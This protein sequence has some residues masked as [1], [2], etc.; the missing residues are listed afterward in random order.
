MNETILRAKRVAALEVVENRNV[1]RLIAVTAFAIATALGAQVFVPLPFTP[2]P[3]TLQTAFVVLAGA[4]LGPRLG[5]ASQLAYLAMGVAGLPVFA[6]GGLGLAHLVGPTGGYLLAFPVTAYVAGLV[7][8]PSGR[9][10]VV[11]LVRLFAGLFIASLVILAG[12]AAW[13]AAVTGDVSGALT[14]AVVPFLIGD[15]VK[16]GLVALIAWRG[17]DRTLGLL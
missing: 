9:K 1:R 2:V 12:G 16:V 5:A 14:L 6:G 7:A 3:M 10:D 15:V 13:L 4:L 17:R 11:E 8:R